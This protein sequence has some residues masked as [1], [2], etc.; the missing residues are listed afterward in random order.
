MNNVYDLGFILFN[1]TL[2]YLLFYFMPKLSSKKQFYGVM[3]DQKY[4]D[5]QELKT[6]DKDFKKLIT[7]NYLFII[8]LSFVLFMKMKNVNIVPA[9]SIIIFLIFEIVIYIKTHTSVKKIKSNLKDLSTSK[10]VAIVDTSIFIER[11]KIINKF[12][13]LFGLNFVVV[14][15]LSIYSIFN[16]NPTFKLIPIH[17]NYYGIADNF[18]ENTFVNFIAQ[19]GL[20]MFVVVIITVLAITTMK[21]RVKVDTENIAGS[22]D[23]TLKFLRNLGYT[24]FG[25]IISLTILYINTLF[26]IIN[27]TNL[28]YYFN[29]LS[30][31][32]MILSSVLLIIIVIKSSNLKSTSS[33]T[34]D[35]E[36]D[37]WIL[38]LIYYNKN[39]PSFMIP[40]KFGIGWTVNAAHPIGKIL[41]I[42][43]VF[44]LV[45]LVYD[46]L[47]S[48]I[49]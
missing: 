11:E 42:A 1:L 30:M 22:K 32:L 9:I 16:Y 20:L 31:V 2:M 24:F 15:F 26:S 33:Y 21:S 7:L 3:I 18:V 13:L 46:I 10:T 8:A 47:K 19:I 35:D 12:K 37:N 23:I 44:L 43:I 17:W 38:G 6:L 34:P 5:L 40:K 36:E 14:L 41:Y 29:I 4:K 45:Y 28:N 49:S 25:L 39:D 48:F 27:G